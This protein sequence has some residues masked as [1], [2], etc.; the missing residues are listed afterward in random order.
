MPSPQHLA[1]DGAVDGRRARRDRNRVAVVDA[2]LTLYGD[3]N[4]DPSSAEIAERAGLSPR[5]LFR[6]FDDVDDL[7]R[8][9]INRHVERVTPLAALDVRASD[10]LDERIEHVVVARVAL[11]E[12]IGSVGTISRLKA[13]FHPV[14]AEQLTQAR[15]YLRNQLREAFATELERASAGPPGAAL[16]AADVLLSYES[17][18]L[19]RADQG[20]GRDAAT[21]VL[22]AAL[23]ALLAPSTVPTS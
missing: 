6:Y 13:P 21:R 19:L 12:A 3:G 9:A 7:C 15:A 17:Y 14:V 1:P 5:S 11:I 20:L 18:Q 10:P 23:G 2:L 8:V 16:A 4:L 22:I